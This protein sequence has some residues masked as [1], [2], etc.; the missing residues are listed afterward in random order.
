MSS[1]T[2]HSLV[3]K[4]TAGFGEAG[5]AESQFKN[6]IAAWS[7]AYVIVI[8]D[9]VLF[10]V[11]AAIAPH[12]ASARNIFNVLDQNAPLMIVSMGTTF[13]IIAGGFD[14]SCG[15]IVSL[16]GVFG[17]YVAKTL[18]APVLGVICGI[19]IGAPAGFANGFLVGWLR[20][21]SFLA[22]L[23]TGLVLGGIALFV[24]SGYSFDLSGSTP[25]RFLGSARLG[26]V[27]V[28]V[29][30]MALIFVVMSVL[31]SYSVF[32]RRVYAVG[33]NPEAA[34]LSGI[35][36]PG[37]RIIVYVIGG[38][39][40]GIAGLILTTRTGVG[41]VF[42]E[43]PTMTLNAIAAVV[44]GGTSISGGRGAIW[45]TLSGAILLALTRNAFNLLDVEPYWQEVVS[46][47]II[48]VAVLANTA[49]G[50][51]SFL[52]KPR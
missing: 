40:A 31:L 15:Q 3:D 30:A 32:G 5:S 14:L 33:S 28:S 20:M 52:I 45:R 46:G 49:G 19:L 12:F 41:S 25:F 23:A 42:A 16:A 35:S 27:P 17:A 26:I 37:V 13:V 38:L 29:M 11:L 4:R 18:D 6:R 34:R 43:A 2:E 36:V 9:V 21:N 7:R 24:T 48:I 39:G 10:M 22:T 51:F 8:L 1:Q 50:S 47:L 44:I